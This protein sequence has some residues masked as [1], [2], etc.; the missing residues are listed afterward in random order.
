MRNT[1][2][3]RHL[4][5][6]SPRGPDTR[7]LVRLRRDCFVETHA[8]DKLSPEDQHLAR[9]VDVHRS[10]RGGDSVI[11]H[12][13]AAAL[14]GLPTWGSTLSRVHVTRAGSSGGRIEQSRHL[15]IDALDPRDVTSR[16]GIAVTTPA[17]AVLDMARICGVEPG[18]VTGDAAI[19]QGLAT[20]AQV[21]ECLDRLPRRK[22]IQQA[23]DAV[24]LIDGRSESVGES[25]S[26]LVLRTEGLPI[27]VLQ[28]L[29]FDEGGSLIGRA[30]FLL[31]GQV[32][33]EFD[34]R[35]KYGAL[36]RA[37]DHP[38]DVVFREKLREDAIRDAGWT[39]VRWTWADL[40]DPARLGE[41][42]RRALERACELPP[43]RGTWLPS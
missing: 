22:G 39:V 43:P 5:I 35:I 2:P 36:I 20:M 38:G 14:W 3:H 26:R 8:W 15:H 18:V 13:S 7:R 24:R 33:G 42:V 27:P 6:R 16:H 4:L 9:V 12:S 11:S 17:R 40:A 37:G 10:L 23:R 28:P 34:G 32:V 21:R 19:H 41:R 1:H 25:R 29:L 31:E 30:D